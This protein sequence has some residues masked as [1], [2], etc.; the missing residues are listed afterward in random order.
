MFHI[1]SDEENAFSSSNPVLKPTRGLGGSRHA[2][3]NIT[4]NKADNEGRGKKRVF[5]NNLTNKQPIKASSQGF[6]NATKPQEKPMKQVN[7][8]IAVYP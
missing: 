8:K 7:L 1:R 3:G 4:N 5:G 6:G 2:L